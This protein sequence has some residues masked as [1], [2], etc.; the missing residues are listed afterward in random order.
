MKVGVLGSGIV[1]QVLAAGFAKHGLQVMMGTRKP[2]D[3]DVQDWLSKTPGAS[4]G[5]FAEATRFGDLV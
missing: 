5:T 4:A 2:A 1:G 3:K